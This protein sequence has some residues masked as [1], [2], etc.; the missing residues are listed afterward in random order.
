MQLSPSE[1]KRTMSGSCGLMPKCAPEQIEMAW[2]NEWEAMK[3]TIGTKSGPKTKSH[4]S[5]GL[6]CMRS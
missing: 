4:F 2:E 5:C 3:F 6:A 1:E